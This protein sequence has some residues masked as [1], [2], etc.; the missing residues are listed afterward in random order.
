M[1]EKVLHYLWKYRLFDAL[2][3]A[4]ADGQS[5]KVYSCG[6]HN[7]SKGGP[8]FMNAHIKIGDTHWYGNIELH[9]KSSDWYIHHHELDAKYDSV[10]LHV[11]WENDEPVFSRYGKVLPTLVL[12]KY[13][14]A[15]VLEYIKGFSSSPEIIS[16]KGSLSIV[17]EVKRKIFQDRLLVERIERKKNILKGDFIRVN[18]NWDHLTLLAIAKVLG[19]QHNSDAFEKLILSLPIDVLYKN[20]DNKLNM[21]ALL[22]GQ[23]GFLGEYYHDK[24]PSVLKETFTFLQKK[25]N[26]QSLSFSQWQWFRIRPASF[27]SLRIA[28]LTGFLLNRHNFFSG[29]IAITDISGFYAYFNFPVSKY[30]ENHYHFDKLTAKTEHRLTEEIMDKIIINALVPLFFL[31]AELNGEE[32]LK[33]KALSFLSLIKPED[34]K[35]L[36]QWSNA[37]IASENAHDS[38]ALIELYNEFCSQKKCLNCAIGHS[39]FKNVNQYARAF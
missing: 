33:E 1:Q 10:I 28:Q 30:W 14:S 6:T 37:G 9:T 23:A 15:K 2:D 18:K 5:V 3:M 21:E 8:D 4:T 27:P 16:C 13:V 11:V 39:I 29:L 25:Y 22:F 19:L 38:Q 31:R 7:T 32:E 24:Y 35:I 36:M 20:N 34:N 26:L 12:Q 17:P